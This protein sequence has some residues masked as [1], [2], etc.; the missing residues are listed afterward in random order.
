M[1][2]PVCLVGEELSFCFT[3]SSV[4]CSVCPSHFLFA[5]V[6]SQGGQPSHSRSTLFDGTFTPLRCACGFVGLKRF[7][8]SW[9]LCFRF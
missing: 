6:L 3:T 9:R 1:T 8:K 4:P 2:R 5:V 7:Y